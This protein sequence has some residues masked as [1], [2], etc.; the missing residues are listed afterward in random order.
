M[1]ELWIVFLGIG[2]IWQGLLIMWVGG[3][4]HAI[5]ARNR[6][7]PQP[8]TPEAFGHFWIEQYRFIGLLLVVGGI[9]VSIGGWP[10]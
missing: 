7:K 4:P 2:M 1:H 3:L 5:T 10:G 8:N 6:P 9:T